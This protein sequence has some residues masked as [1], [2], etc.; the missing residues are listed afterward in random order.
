M[1]NWV[2][3]KGDRAVLTEGIYV[4]VRATDFRHPCF[5]LKP[6]LHRHIKVH[7]PTGNNMEASKK[8]KKARVRL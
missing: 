7:Y 4:N 3:L 1:R 5:K 8:K 6:F 2:H